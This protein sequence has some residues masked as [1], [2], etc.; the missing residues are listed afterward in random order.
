MLKVMRDQFH[1]L[2]WILIAVVAAFIIGFVFIDMGMGGAAGGQKLDAA[3]AA[4]VNGET[5]SYT[6]FNR[7]VYNMEENYKRMYGAQFTPEMA[8]AMGLPKQ[9]LDSLVE[10]RLL[11]QQAARLHLTATPDEVR[12]KI[13]DIPTLNPDGKFIGNE[14]YERFVTR[15]LRYESTAAFE[16]DLARD[17]TLEKLESALQS[18]MIVSPKAAETEYRRQNENAK[19]RYVLIPAMKALPT[20]QITPAEVEAYYAKNQSKYTHGEQRDLKYLVADVNRIRL[21]VNPT[22]AE[23]RKHYDASKEDYKA[24]ESAHILH[25]LIKVPTTATPAEDAAAKARA[26]ALVAQLRGGADFGKLAR[27]NSGDPSSSGNG[28]DMGFIERGQTVES[29][30]TAAFSIPL[31]TISAPIRSTEYG[32]HII[33]VLERRPAGYRSFE[34]VRAQLSSQVAE[35]T[36]KD[37][38]RD[39]MT[40]IAARLKASKPKTPEEFTSYANDKVSSNDT[41]W[42]AKTDQ[43]PGLGFNQPLTTWAFGAKQGDAGDIV[44]TQR[45][46]AIPYVFGIRP[47]GISPLTEI[48]ARVEADAKLEKAREL[49]RTSLANAMSGAASIDAIAAKVGGTA[50]DTTVTRQ[51]SISGLQGDTS[52]LV[53]A[54]MSSKMGDLKGPVVVGD[55]AVAFQVT[56]IKKVDDAEAA[57][58]SAQ[59]M[60]ALRGQQARSIRQSLMQRLRKDAKIEVNPKVLEQNAP[61]QQGA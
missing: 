16:D 32:Y 19:I 6:E 35:Q 56:E 51:G 22:E 39:E 34:E 18:S 3:Y 17:I 43:I 49:A 44:G 21:T 20:I 1:R 47:A 36:A 31:N 37:L 2:K 5:I 7:A 45:G 40:R 9:V 10:Q 15:Q 23:L 52:A 54:T 41:Q 60:D 59:Y 53:D 57:K 55:G 33:K 27:E 50:S 24:Q 38:A 42:F 25:I 8:T 28:G 4:R 12:K 61:R 58:N 11:L 26:E 46:P 13:L 48:R 14:L 30:D 29:F